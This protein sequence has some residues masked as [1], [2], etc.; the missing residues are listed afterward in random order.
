MK[1]YISF[2]YFEKKS[3]IHGLEE[4]SMAES[5]HQYASSIISAF[6]DAR[7]IRNAM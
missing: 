4:A 7:P 5:F 2:D 1:S 6:N 3:C